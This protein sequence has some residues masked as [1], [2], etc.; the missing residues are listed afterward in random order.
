MQNFQPR[1]SLTAKIRYGYVEEN[2][3]QYPVQTALAPGGFITMGGKIFTAI[4]GSNDQINE[5][6]KTVS[7]RR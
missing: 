3:L 4:F 5:N 2:G 7:I 1:D 6:G